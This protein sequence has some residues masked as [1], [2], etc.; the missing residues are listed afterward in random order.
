MKGAPFLSKMVYEKGKV[1]DLGWSLPRIQQTHP[2][3]TSWELHT[4]MFTGIPYVG[5]KNQT[6]GSN[7]LNIR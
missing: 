6:T 5:G 2:K 7:C 1:L 3:E 4:W